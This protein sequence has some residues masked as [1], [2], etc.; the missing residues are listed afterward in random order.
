MQARRSAATANPG[1]PVARAAL[2]R[3]VAYSVWDP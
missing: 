2:F 1:F 3:K